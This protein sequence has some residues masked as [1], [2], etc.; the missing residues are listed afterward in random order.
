[1]LDVIHRHSSEEMTE[2]PGYSIRLLII[3]TPHNAVSEWYSPRN[4][5]RFF[6]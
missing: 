5:P 1:M 4:Q 2:Q 3:P 6:L